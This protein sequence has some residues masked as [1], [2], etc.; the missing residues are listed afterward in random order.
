M[1]TRIRWDQLEWGYRLNYP[2]GQDV[3]RITSL[4]TGVPNQAKF[5]LRSAQVVTWTKWISI[6]DAVNRVSAGTYED[7]HGPSAVVVPA[8]PLLSRS[9]IIFGKAATLG[10]LTDMYEL[11]GLDRFIGREVEFTWG[12]D[13]GGNGPPP[14]PPQPLPPVVLDAQ[15]MEDPFVNNVKT[16]KIAADGSLAGDGGQTVQGFIRTDSSSE[17]I[18]ATITGFQPSGGSHPVSIFVKRIATANGAP[19][20]WFRVNFVNNQPN[21]AIWVTFYHGGNPNWP[22]SPVPTTVAFNE[23]PFH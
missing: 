5:I 23:A 16:Y 1:T 13:W 11:D 10:I 17:D 6:G 7:N 18:L 20:I 19:G 22:V 8:N 14:G 9:T 21:G 15:P 2:G 4:R 12:W 3:I